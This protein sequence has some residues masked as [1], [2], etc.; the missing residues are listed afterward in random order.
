MTVMNEDWEKVKA[1]MLFKKGKREQFGEL[2]ASQPHCNLWE[3]D[4][5][6]N[7]E[8]HFQT[9]KVQK[10]D[11]EKSALIY[12][13][14]M[15]VDKCHTFWRKKTGLDIAYPDGPLSKSFTAAIPSPLLPVLNRSCSSPS[16]GSSPD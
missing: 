8:S 5:A 15:I 6:N 4:G 7:S 11:W 12:K 13:R 9:H 16:S 1:T 2:L 14:R 10:G 3:D